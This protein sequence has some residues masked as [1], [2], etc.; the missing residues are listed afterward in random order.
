[1]AI[2]RKELFMC[3]FVLKGTFA[4]TPQIDGFQFLE[5]HFLVSDGE[6]I[7]GLFKNLPEQYKNLRLYDY[8]GKI[9]IPGMSDLHIHAPQYAFRGIGQ[10]IEGSNWDS[11]FERYAFPDES[12]YMDLDYAGKAYERLA[13]DLLKTPTTRLSMFATIHRPATELL[14]D[15]LDKKGFGGYVGKVN[16]DRNSIEGLLESTEETLSETEKWINECSGK[17]G[18]I[19]P[20]ITPRYIPSCTDEAMAGLSKLIEKYDLPVQSHLSE[21]L[22]EIEWVKS[23]KPEITCYGQG[24]DMYNMLGGKTKCIQ[25]HCIFPTD[26]EFELISRRENLWVAH[27]ADANLHSCGTSA[28]ILKY[29]RAGVKVGL[30]SDS[31]GGSFI[32]LFRVMWEAIIASKVHWAYTVRKNEPFVKKDFLSLANAFYLATKGGGSF[33]GNVGSFEAGY[34]C[35]AVV[36]DDSRLIDII[37][38][39]TYERLERMISLSDDREI[40]AKFINGKKV[41]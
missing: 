17:Y 21:G 13:N 23:L 37:P 14:M 16:M 4:H 15:I 9:I 33:F 1:M 3:A 12:R 27:C 7:V 24:Y 2:T 6:K 22:D 8:T 34:Q 30:G 41:L 25:A 40:A 20:I 32:N 26:E 29:I 11:W 35:D 19:K 28:P 39:T 36:L 38:R 5:D 18:L 10:N 31:A